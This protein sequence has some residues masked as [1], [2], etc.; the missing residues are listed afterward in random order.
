MAHSL[1]RFMAWAAVLVLAAGVALAADTAASPFVGKW[2]LNVAKS[3][4]EGT[5]AVK[6][7]TITITDAG[8]GKTHNLAEWVDGDGGKG[9]A[10]YTAEAGGKPSPISGYANADSVLVK[11][12]GPRS[13]HMSLR[14][15]GKEVE[16]GSYR[17]SA[18]GKTMHGTEGGTDE[19]G[20]KY[21]WTEV[22]ERQ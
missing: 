6:S 3:K 16:W 17:V 13:L 7:Y 22:F 11:S 10:E 1:S 9:Q 20:T 19:N 14:K 12:T 5:S 15:A 2:S 8:G 21:R 4:F 18:D